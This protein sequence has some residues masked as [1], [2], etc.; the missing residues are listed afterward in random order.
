MFKPQ[1]HTAFADWLE[2][3][4]TARSGGSVI[5]PESDVRR[6]PKGTMSE[7]NC[8]GLGGIVAHVHTVQFASLIDIRVVPDC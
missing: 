5:R 6:A 4:L 7:A 8:A 2:W 1:P 3:L